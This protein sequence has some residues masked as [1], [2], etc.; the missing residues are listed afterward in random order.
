M[1]AGVRIAILSIILTASIPLTAI[2]ANYANLIGI[3]VVWLGIVMV[4]GIVF[5]RPGK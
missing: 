2:A 4:S 1:S 3:A 5:G